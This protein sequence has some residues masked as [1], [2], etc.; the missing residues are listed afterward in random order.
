MGKCIGKAEKVPNKDILK[1]LRI[2]YEGLDD[3][4]IRNLFLDIACFFDHPFTRE[5]AESI[6]A[7]GDSYAK[8]G[9]STLI[10]NSLIEIYRE[11]ETMSAG[12]ISYGK[13][14]GQL[15]L[16]NTKSLKIVEG[17]LMLKMS[18]KYWKKI[19]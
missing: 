3:K 1:V 6:L 10:D 8:I 9:I 7:G 13:W 15:F 2:S 16:M 14:V 12:M 17:C 19:R 5:Y 18:A 11:D 4:T